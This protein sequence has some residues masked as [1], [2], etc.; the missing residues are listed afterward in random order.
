MPID[1]KIVPLLGIGDLFVLGIILQSLNKIGLESWFVSLIP[2]AG[3]LIA[4]FLGLMVH[5][6][7]ALPIMGG[8]TILFLL[9]KNYLV[10]K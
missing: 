1:G 8:V 9:A 2:I 10:R 7:Y 5:G 3:L 6:I 4:L